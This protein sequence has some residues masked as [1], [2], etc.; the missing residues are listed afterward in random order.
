MKTAS[1]KSTSE[2]QMCRYTGEKKFASRSNFVVKIEI[3]F[4]LFIALPL[5]THFPLKELRRN[6][7]KF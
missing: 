4:H 6:F 3:F 7:G 2:N 1:S 5:E